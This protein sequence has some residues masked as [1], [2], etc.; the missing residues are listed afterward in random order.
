MGLSVVISETWYQRVLAATLRCICSH[1]LIAETGAWRDGFRPAL[2][3]LPPAIPSVEQVGE[4]IIADACNL[5]D[6]GEAN[7]SSRPSQ[8]SPGV[9]SQ[10]AIA[11]S[12]PR[13]GGPA[14]T[15]LTALGGLQADMKK[16]LEIPRASSFLRANPEFFSNPCRPC[17]RQAWPALPSSDVR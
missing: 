16:A 1:P 14:R 3:M 11:Q 17:R 5:M 7:I 6:H 12:A 13:G 8:T 10:M 15:R 9:R 4:S 2:P